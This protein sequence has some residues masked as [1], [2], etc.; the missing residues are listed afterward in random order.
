V[1]SIYCGNI[2]GGFENIILS[3]NKGREADLGDALFIN[4]K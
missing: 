2:F 1:L 3:E 4:N